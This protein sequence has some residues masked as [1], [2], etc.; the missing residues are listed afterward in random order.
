MTEDA[1]GKDSVTGD[2]RLSP[3]VRLSVVGIAMEAVRSG[4]EGDA[5]DPGEE[6]SVVAGGAG[7]A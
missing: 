7:E 4:M 1:A 2:V 3:G 5:T 6:N